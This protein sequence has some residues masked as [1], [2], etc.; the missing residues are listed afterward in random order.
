MSERR[1]AEKGL[2][3]LLVQSRSDVLPSPGIR[4]VH[5]NEALALNAMDCTVDFGLNVR[6]TLSGVGQIASPLQAAWVL[7]FVTTRLDHMYHGECQFS[8]ESQL[9]AFRSWLLMRCQLTWPCNECMLTDATLRELVSFWHEFPKFSISQLVHPSTWPDLPCQDLTIAAVLDHVIRSCCRPDPRWVL[10]PIDEPETPW[11]DEMV[12]D[13][14]GDFSLSVGVSTVTL[15]DTDGSC[16]DFGFVAGSTVADFLNAHG[17]LNGIFRVSTISD[18]LGSFISP[19]VIIERGQ[20]IQVFL[21]RGPDGQCF[22]S[23]GVLA[24][25]SLTG[26]GS[27]GALIACNDET[28]HFTPPAVP[29]LEV[30]VSGESGP[31]PKL[32]EEPRVDGIQGCNATLPDSTAAE[33]PPSVGVEHYDS[34]LTCPPGQGLLGNANAL[35]ALTEQQFL[36]LT[37]P[38]VE[39]T[40]K[41]ASLRCQL[42]K[43]SDRVKLLDV[44][45]SLWSDYEISFHLNQILLHLQQSCNPGDAVTLP[46]VVDPILMTSW[47]HDRGFSVAQ[48]ASSHSEVRDKK[49]QVIGIGCLDGHWIPFQI[50]PCGSHANI[51]TWDAPQHEHGRLNHVLEVISEHLGFSTTLINRQHRMFFMSGRCGALAIHFL[52]NVVHGAMLPISPSEAE[53]VH[54]TLRDKFAKA[55]AL[56]EFVVRPWIWGSGDTEGD[57]P[58]SDPA[59][60][61]SRE[62]RP[63]PRLPTGVEGTFPMPQPSWECGPLPI[64]PVH[65]SSDMSTDS[66]GWETISCVL[67]LSPF[68]CETDGRGPFDIGVRPPRCGSFSLSSQVSELLRMD[69]RQMLATPPPC[70]PDPMALWLIRHQVMLTH[71][72]LSILPIQYGV[73]ADDEIRFQLQ[74]LCRQIQSCPDCRLPGPAFDLDPLVCS[75]WLDPQSCSGESWAW[76]HPEIVELQITVFGVFRIDDH[77]VPVILVPAGTAVC[78]ITSDFDQW[79]APKLVN[80]LHRLVVA[81]GFQEITFDHEA[82]GYSCR[83]VCGAIAI[84]FI[85]HRLLQV[86]KITTYAAA[87]GA[88]AL[89]RHQFVQMLQYVQRVPRPWIWASGDAEGSEQ[90][91]K[92]WRSEQSP[93]N[94]PGESSS[95]R[96]PGFPPPSSVGQ[97]STHV[98]IPIDDR[99]DLFRLHGNAMGDDEIRFHLFALQSQRFKQQASSQERKPDVICF[100]SL[101]FLSWDSVGHILTEKWCGS[102]PQVKQLGH[103]IVGIVLEGDHWLPLWIVPGGM[104]LVVHTFD[105]IVDYDIFDGKLRWLGLHLGFEEVVIHRV[106]NGLPTHDMCGAHA[107]AFLAH[108]LLGS[109][110]PTSIEELDTMRVNMRAS[111]VQAMH[112]GSTCFCPIV[113]GTGGTGA[114]VKSLSTELCGHGVPADLAEQR[115][116]QAIRAIG[117]ESLIQALQTKNPWRQLKAL[118]NNVQF[119]FVLPSELEA[120]VAANKGKPV[121]PKGKKDRTVPGLPV[122]TELDPSKLSVLDGTFRSGDAVLSQ[123]S[124][125]QIGPISRGFVLMTLQE[126]EPYLKAGKIVSQEPLA[127]V[128]FHR[129][130]VQLH[131][132]LPQCRLVVPCRCTVDNEPVL[133]EATLVQIGSHPVSKFA[134][135]SLVSLDSPDVRTIRIM[136]FRDEVA[137]WDD[138][139]K[140]PVKSLVHMFPVLKRCMTSGC[141]CAAWH[142]EEDLP[143]REPILD[144]WKRQFMKTGFKPVEATKADIFCVSVRIP[145]CLLERVLNLSGCAGAYVEPRN[146][147]GTQVL[148]EYM[149]VWAGKLSHRE[150][151]HL[152]QTNPA[153]TGLARI[154][155]RRGLRVHADQAHEIHKVVRPDTLFLPQGAR[156]QFIAGPFPFGVDR[157]AISRAMKLANWQCKPL[158][159]ASPQPG[160]GVMWL[161][162]AVEEPPSSIVYTNHGEIL[163]SKHRPGEHADRVEPAKPIASPAT[164]ALCG[165]GPAVKDEDPWSRHDPWSKFQ[166]STNASACV[167]GAS[168]SMHQMES[169]IQAAVM[170]KMPQSMEDDVPDRLVVLEGQVQQLMHQQSNMDVQF[171]EFSHQQNQNVSSLQTQ[172]NVQSQQ[173]QGQIE[174]QHQNMQAMFETQLAQIRGLLSKRPRDDN[175]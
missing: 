48:W 85:Q 41:L 31:L 77:W 14:K 45:Q 149:V 154:G 39:S 148:Q 78:I 161:I 146:A 11:L 52:H 95:G 155:D 83:S 134:G 110:L 67:G 166:P 66:P 174:S 111:F 167:P 37:V 172:L 57:S 122:P 10:P 127:L 156:T 38:S 26:A 82:R 153:V 79:I 152:K 13:P 88:H 126:A 28:I 4:H 118:A 163:I 72:R 58:V 158:Q 113:W 51:F 34:S 115:A 128:I 84:N 105:D 108:I 54:A 3:G 165:G 117:S 16:L 123:I 131:S 124:T 91:E 5:P 130:D 76:S 99:I 24:T 49:I 35:L 81:L 55:V 129:A 135:G 89:F 70:I 87:W 69:S 109:D 120:S 96:D 36:R 27:A 173:L 150:L 40:A 22:P 143:I 97:V 20:Q 171:K 139:V 63:L 60:M 112:E 175:E 59:D 132:M 160:R 119:K 144:L 86:P 61:S 73:W 137:D 33:S 170:A 142:N 98:C 21:A 75:T 145:A 43:S 19:D 106:P 157:Q 17:K 64:M 71:D 133:A 169:R 104:I 103:Q 2:F 94:E 6:L 18:G 42:L 136:V 90:S 121:V 29:Q 65:A 147:D 125:T 116:A 8:P 74:C 107:L 102:F 114:L 15:I 62:C 151:L 25:S 12:C 47:L 93:T 162:Q 68:T 100:E 80:V 50:V 23:E 168:E 138:F 159:P 164:L 46:L 140:G 30:D 9:W 44:Q 53:T 141:A 7:S 32:P 1:L 56:T 101:N 92:S